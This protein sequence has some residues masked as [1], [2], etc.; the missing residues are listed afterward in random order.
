MRKEL[1][2][3]SVVFDKSI[4]HGLDCYKASSIDRSAFSAYDKKTG[5]IEKGKVIISDKSRIEKG[6]YKFCPDICEKVTLIKLTPC[7]DEEII[8]SYIEK[9]TRGFVIEGY[10]TG[11]IPERVIEKLR[12]AKENNIPSMLIT[13]C[14]SGGTDLEIYEVG[15]NALCAGIIDGKK[16]GAE[17]AL[18]IMM[19]KIG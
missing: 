16:L 1:K 9:G 12:K 13:Q 6:V 3:V 17:G 11:G 5:F 2:C 18:A 8:D 15:N 14:K 19:K 4:F 7:F 10:G